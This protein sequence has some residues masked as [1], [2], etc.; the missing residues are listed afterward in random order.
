MLLKNGLGHVILSP[1]RFAQGKLFAC[2]SDP[3]EVNRGKNPFHSAL[4]VNFAKNLNPLF[5][6]RKADASLRSA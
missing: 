3:D 5:S 4:R 1:I 6:I 2:H